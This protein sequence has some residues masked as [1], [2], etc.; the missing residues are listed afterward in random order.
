MSEKDFIFNLLDGEEHA[1]SCRKPLDD[2]ELDEVAGGKLNSQANKWWKKNKNKIM[3]QLGEDEFA[4][5]M[6]DLTNVFLNP[7]KSY[8]LSYL[9]GKL[10]DAGVNL[11]KLK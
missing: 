1:S 7:N 4:E 3:N 5:L 2:L 9:Q 6:D 11:K 10:E 8:S